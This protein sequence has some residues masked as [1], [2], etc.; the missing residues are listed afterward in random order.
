MRVIATLLYAL[1]P[2]VSSKFIVS[3]GAV[4]GFSPSALQLL[5]IPVGEPSKEPN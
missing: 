2:S 3:Q 1:I 5:V 4:L